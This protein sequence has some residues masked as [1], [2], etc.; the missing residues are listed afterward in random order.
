MT[1][2]HFH[3]KLDTAEVYYCIK[4]HGFLIM[5]D[6]NG[7]MEIQEMNPGISVYVPPGFAHRSVNVSKN[8]PFIMF[9]VF[10]ADAGHDYKSIEKKGFRKL[11]V[12]K[13]GK[14]EIIDNPKWNM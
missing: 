7:K 11:V 1:K 4:G 6:T 13:N 2:G 10:R 5:E 14:P 3:K 8:E 12:D 9:F